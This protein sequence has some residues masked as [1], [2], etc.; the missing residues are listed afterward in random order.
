MK[1]ITIVVEDSKQ[2][3]GMFSLFPGESDFKK[4]I[5]DGVPV[6]FIASSYTKTLV[7]TIIVCQSNRYSI[8]LMN[9]K[10]NFKEKE[11][12]SHFAGFQNKV[13]FKRTKKQGIEEYKEYIKAILPDI[14]K[15]L[16][17][18]FTQDKFVVVNEAF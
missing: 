13:Y 12:Y 10:F 16:G 1:E 15:L 18:T 9:D 4:S 8:N 3:S 17:V 14:E 7:E 5:L 11:S 6:H 2:V